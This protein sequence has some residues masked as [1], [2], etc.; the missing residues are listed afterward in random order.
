MDGYPRTVAQAQFFER[1]LDRY[2]MGLDSVILLVVPD[3]E[4]IRRVSGRWVC[5]NP[6]CKTTYHS[7]SKPPKVPG[8]CDECQTEL[9][10]RDDDREE[11]VR[12]RLQIF[13]E[14]NAEL[15]EFYRK[16]RLL[17]EVPGMGDVETIY[18]N[19][20]AALN[21]NTGQRTSHNG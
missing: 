1:V 5:P 6:T 7:M 2:G 4:I 13:H 21:H 8:V 20:V 14:L 11:T 10:Q 19:I 16:T 18:R 3:Q 15:L 9:I 12:K 17:I